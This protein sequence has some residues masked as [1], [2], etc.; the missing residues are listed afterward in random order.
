MKKFWEKLSNNLKQLWQT[1]R[2]WLII[3]VIVI[4]L[5]ISQVA[6]GSAGQGELTFINPTKLSY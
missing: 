3:S 4:L 6:R 2:K 1:K 5:I